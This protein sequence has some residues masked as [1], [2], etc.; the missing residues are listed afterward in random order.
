MN[1]MMG[2][3][4]HEAHT[5]EFHEPTTSMTAIHISTSELDTE[6]TEMLLSAH[7]VGF[8][9][10]AHHDRVTIILVNYV[11]ADQ[12]IYGRLEGGPDVSTLH[13]HQWV[14]FSVS[15]IDG[16]YDWRSV[17]VHGSVYL[18]SPQASQPEAL[19]YQATLA[20]L[21][22]VVPAVLTPRDPAPQRTQLFRLHVDT[23]VGQSSRSSTGP[24][25][26]RH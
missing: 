13:H 9:A 14:A 25:P 15:E 26:Q 24:D 1:A 19:E 22:S 10:L 21:R 3:R 4:I 18:L 5:H 11:Y 23:M 8:M 7:H 12:S 2:R 20:R 17:L 6:T 16:I